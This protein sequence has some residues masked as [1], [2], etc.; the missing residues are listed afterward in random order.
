MKNPL[1]LALLAGF[2]FGLWPVVARHISIAALWISFLI[3][4]G[5]LLIV[6]PTALPGM[7]SGAT[8]MNRLIVFGVIA[9]V[10]NGLGM[11]AY[12]RI[13]SNTDWNVSKYVP[14]VAVASIATAAIGAFLIFKEPLTIQ[15]SLGLV[16]AALAVWLL[17]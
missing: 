1:I 2:F 4:V 3:P 10:I 7:I 8:P 11:L 17:S 15:K 12:G 9:G 5:T 13:L 14:I 16:F 6:A